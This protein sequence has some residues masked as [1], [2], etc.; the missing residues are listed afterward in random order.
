MPFLATKHRGLPYYISVPFARVN[1]RPLTTARSIKMSYKELVIPIAAA[2]LIW[3]GRLSPMWIILA[4]IIGGLVY[5]LK[6]KKD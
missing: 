6:I 2:L 1:Q 3:Q 4:A 5:G